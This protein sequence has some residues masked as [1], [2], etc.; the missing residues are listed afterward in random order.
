MDICKG[1][2]LQNSIMQIQA[3]DHPDWQRF[4]LEAQNFK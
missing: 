2:E 4:I 3:M 1:I